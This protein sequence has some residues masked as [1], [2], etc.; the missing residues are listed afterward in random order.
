MKVECM[1]RDWNEEPHVTA[2][3]KQVLSRGAQN[4]EAQAPKG[5]CDV[6]SLDIPPEG[7][8]KSA[9]GLGDGEEW[10]ATCCR[11]YNGFISPHPH[12]T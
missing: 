8:G 1:V 9:C 5:I 2:D 6:T 4:Y 11:W 12:G 7:W 10:V 3:N